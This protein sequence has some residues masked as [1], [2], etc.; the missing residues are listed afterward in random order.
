MAELMA[1]RIDPRVAE[2]AF[3]VGLV[4]AL[5]LL[6]GTPL[7]EVLKSLA[8][9]S[10]LEDALLGRRGVLGG[11]VSDVLAWEIGGRG[12]LHSGLGMISVAEAYLEALAWATEVCG[13]METG[14][15]TL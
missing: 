7:V 12:S 15:A 9:A 8:L 5:D 6:L 13:T 14:T 2:Q 3:T 11:I 4:S 10:D 1:Q